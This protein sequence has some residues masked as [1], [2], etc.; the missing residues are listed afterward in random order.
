[1]TS[2]RHVT[3]IVA[4]T[5]PGPPEDFAPR[6]VVKAGF[7]SSWNPPCLELQLFETPMDWGLGKEVRFREI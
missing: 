1:M 3:F 5:S 7:D 2:R 6:P 4:A